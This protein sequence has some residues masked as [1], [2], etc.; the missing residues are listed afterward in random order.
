MTRAH[1]VRASL[2]L[3]VGE[4]W[5]DSL[6]GQGQLTQDWLTVFDLKYINDKMVG[7]LRRASGKIEDYCKKLAVKAFSLSRVCVVFLKQMFCV[8]SELISVASCLAEVL[9][10]LTNET[11][12]VGFFPPHEKTEK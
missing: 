8:C 9:E 2:F 10:P 4:P 6:P 3:G 7:G 11:A 1:L 5:L 12:N